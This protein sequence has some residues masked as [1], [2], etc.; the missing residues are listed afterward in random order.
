MISLRMQ[1][2]R[3]FER[4]EKLCLQIISNKKNWI[5]WKKG[6]Q[7]WRW[8]APELFALLFGWVQLSPKMAQPFTRGSWK[9][10]QNDCRIAAVVNGALNQK[11]TKP[12]NLQSDNKVVEVIGRE[13]ATD[14]VLVV[15]E[16]LQSD[17]SWSNKVTVEIAS[18]FGLFL[19]GQDLTASFKVEFGKFRFLWIT[20]FGFFVAI[21]RYRW[22]VNI[23]AFGILAANTNRDFVKMK[24]IE[25]QR[26]R[27]DCQSR[28]LFAVS[29][30]CRALW[31]I[32]ERPNP[33]HKHLWN[34]STTI[35][36]NR[37]RREGK[38]R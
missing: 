25:R 38:R 30:T 18:V 23:S 33:D 2:D 1:F 8:I 35:G 36:R 10:E 5:F 7:N 29:C 14:T 11:S 12:W 16:R 37:M 15:A 13:M 17:K 26:W 27:R 20:L 19:N 3:S 31:Q 24:M 28:L 6:L 4:I 32:D 9:V 22:F 34:C 21:G